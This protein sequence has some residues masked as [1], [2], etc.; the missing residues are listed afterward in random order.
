MDYWIEVKSH[1][2]VTHILVNERETVTTGIR[3]MKRRQNP[4]SFPAEKEIKFLCFLFTSNS[5]IM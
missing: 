5:E 2:K 3:H 4:L 1:R